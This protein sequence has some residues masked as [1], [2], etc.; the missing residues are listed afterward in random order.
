M[1]EALGVEGMEQGLA[2]KNQHQQP[3]GFSTVLLHSAQREKGLHCEKRD[4]GVLGD[5]LPRGHT[6]AGAPAHR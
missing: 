1:P 4:G 6:L 2:H 3:T 5:S